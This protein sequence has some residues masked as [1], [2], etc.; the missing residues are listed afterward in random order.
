MKKQKQHI[1]KSA[2]VHQGIAPKW[3]GWGIFIFTLLLYANT[4]THDFMLDDGIVITKNTLVQKGVGGIAGIFSKDTFWGFT[5]QDAAGQV[6]AGGRYRPLSLAVFALLFQFFG[7]NPLVFHAVT[8]LL[9]AAT[10]M[11]LYHTLRLLF[12]FKMSE[13]AGNTLAFVAALLFTAH[14]VHTEVVANVKSCDEILALAGCLG[15]WYGLLRFC[16]T[17]ANKW[18]VIAGISLLLACFS[19]ENAVTFALVLPLSIWWFR[20]KQAQQSFFL[21]DMMPIW[22]ALIAFLSVRSVVLGSTIA[23]TPPELLNN[24]YL[25]WVN[26]SWIPYSFAEKAA[27]ILYSLGKYA[28]LLVFPHPLTHDYYPRYVNYI[29]LAHPMVLLSLLLHIALLWFVWQG[30][31]RR[32]VVGFGILFYFCTIFIVSNIVFPIGTH[33]NE[34]FLFM[35]SVGFCVAVAAGIATLMAHHRAWAWGLTGILT[36]G[37][38]FKT[39]TRNPVWANDE[40]L[41]LTDVLTSAN[42][43]RANNAAAGVLLNQAL[44]TNDP[45]RRQNLFRQCLPYADKALDIYPDYSHAYAIRAR[46]HYFLGNYD[47]SIADYRQALRLDANNAQHRSYLAMALRDGGQYYGEQKNDLPTALRYLEESWRLSDKDPET[48][49]LTG[50]AYLIQQQYPKAVQWYTKATALSPNNPT[51]LYDLGTATIQ[52]GDAARGQ[53]LQQQALQINPNLLKERGR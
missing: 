3:A 38:A 14:P 51:Y 36:A 45:T 50:V 5:Q 8:V 29:G 4:L 48:A 18:R 21:K 28:Q 1:E 12:S 22:G 53:A 32:D 37:F 43:A 17:G 11:L 27:A 23:Q 24:P 39:I 9:F 41:V 10:C 20:P 25:K 49:W 16:D 46:A 26:D 47:A 44:R 7:A 31:H 40:R 19:K 52:A 33:L 2:S 30:R 42:S 35:P 6:V 13:T 34:R 15:A